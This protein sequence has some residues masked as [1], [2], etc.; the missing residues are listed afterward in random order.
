MATASPRICVIAPEFIG[1]FPNGGVGT[2]CYWEAMTLARAGFDVTVLYTGPTERESPQHWE[3]AYGSGPF[4][5]VDLARWASAS[6]VHVDAMVHRCPEARV[7]E[8]VL[9]FLRGTRF[10][11]LLF[12]EFLGHGCRTLQARRSGESLGGARAGVTL[13]SSRQWIYR[14]MRRL[15][16]A[17][18]D[19]YVDFLE[20]ESAGLADSVAAPSQHMAAWAAEHWK[21]DGASVVPYCYDP[22]IEQ[23]GT[24]G[25][26]EG[27]F[28]HLVFF[29]R[30]ETRKG[31]HLFCRAL[32]EHAAAR[33]PVQ[34]VTFLGK[35]S[36][37]DERPSDEFIRTA[38]AGSG[39][40]IQIVDTLG[41][42]EALQWLE[43]QRNTLVVAP[44]LV[45]NLPYALIELV[46]RRLPFVST[47]I[48]GI[49][50]IVGP[51]NGHLL[52][53][54]SVHGVAG[55]L[56]DVHRHG[57]ITIDY[58]SAYSI[59]RS[60][61]AHVAWV[62]SLLA[63]PVHD[64]VDLPAGDVVV[65]DG[66]D[67]AIPL[68]RLQFAAAD[69]GATDWRFVTWRQWR[70][71][72]DARPA[73]FLSRT[74]RPRP[75]LLTRLAA[76]LRNRDVLAATTYYASDTGD[77]TTIHAPLG[78][79]LESGWGENVFGGACFAA[80]GDTLALL[81]GLFPAEFQFWPAYAAI[82]GSTGRLA[83]VPECLYD[84]PPPEE[85]LDVLDSVGA[86]Y[87]QY[88]SE[89]LDIRWVLKHAAATQNS[90]APHAAVG[91]ALY[92][93]LVHTP[94]I[95]VQALAAG[96]D[97]RLVDDPYVRDMRQL[98]GRL[99]AL[100]S[101]WSSTHPRVFVYGAGQ[102]TRLL[103]MLEPELARHVAGF[104]DRRAI[105]HFLGKPCLRPEQVTAGIADAVLYSSRE[106]EREMYMRLARVNVRHVLL[107]ADGP[108]APAETASTRLQRRFG[109][110][111]AAIDALRGMYH[112]PAWVQ[113][114]C[115]GGDAEFLLELVTAIDPKLVVELG[116]ASGTSSAALLFAM[117]RLPA[118]PTER[119]LISGDVRPTCYF[120]PARA[121]GAAVHDMYPRHR[122]TWLLD[123]DTDAR[124][125]RQ[126]VPPGSADLCFIDANHSHPWPLLDLLHLSTVARPESWIALHDIEL[127]RLYPQFP[128]HGAQW[129]FAAWPFNKVHGVGGSV[130]IGAVQ[131]PR[132]LE[133]LV[134]VALEL[135]RR[136]WE[137]TPTTWDVHLPDVFSAV[138]EFVRPR[139]AQPAR[140]ALAG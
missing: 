118:W 70:S 8:L 14:G 2:A 34:K 59:A 126:T 94:D 120:D 12:Q 98:R 95:Q 44:S 90:L 68:A 114:G 122:T 123:T 65:V 45:D 84:A 51:A 93:R 42:I 35:A 1:P 11:L 67:E 19:L 76:A 41:S 33:G 85:S 103:F 73:V 81:R 4:R 31:L 27:P 88:G 58:R 60:N 52:C 21:I 72:T 83:V 138:S 110:A 18:E 89:R 7:S 20:R 39:L 75:G 57:R 107:Y 108:P 55:L 140:A 113:G 128:D 121:T 105:T 54:A 99:A 40:E 64:S 32:A 116:V 92:N 16:D 101:E 10:D 117:D 63:A 112:P 104:I 43:S 69:P 9:E 26:H 66:R 25:E 53:D 137:H 29:G 79:S 127:P 102:H 115:S 96:W 3:A 119:L 48:G 106:F 77:G 131:L 17:R 130:N 30:L 37:V 38:L 82:T 100:V 139:L 24:V 56:A 61:A 109:H 124:R 62:E 91:R 15:P 71:S 80:R 134:P 111:D 47:R 28:T 129:L 49:P 5:Y 50:E 135:L 132:D 87:R 97:D 125:L 13:H 78:G 46:A 23:P 22:G 6:P 133:Q 136:P 86:A 74:V 36:R